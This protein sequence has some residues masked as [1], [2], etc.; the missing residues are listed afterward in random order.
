MFN[1]STSSALRSNRLLS[2]YSFHLQVFIYKILTVLLYFLS[3]FSE[4]FIDFFVRSYCFGWVWKI[5]MKFFSFC[6]EE[7]AIF[8][9]VV[10]NRNH[11]I[12]F[13]IP[14]FIN[15]V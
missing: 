7:W 3:D 14:V 4:L 12:K 8:F 11:K 5:M 13:Y 1:R 15:V 6:W 10:A 9:S 2:A